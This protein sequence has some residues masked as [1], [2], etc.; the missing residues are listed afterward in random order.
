ML[1]IRDAVPGDEMLVHR[2]MYELAVYEKLTDKFKLTPDIVARDMLGPQRACFCDLAFEGEAPV[3]VMTWHP[4]Y[5]SFAASRGLYLEDL[6]VRPDHRGKGYGKALL[7]HLAARARAEK[8][9]HIE[10]TV[11]DWNAPSIAFYESLK[12]ERAKGWLT[13]RL[14][15]DALARLGEP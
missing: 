3:G 5:S 11:L 12:A 7:A 4:T 1:A 14:S 9:T 10:W 13:Y 8:R 15:G 6:F 2:L